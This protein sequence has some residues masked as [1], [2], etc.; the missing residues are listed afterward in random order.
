MKKQ[1]QVPVKVERIVE[2]VTEMRD[3]IIEEDGGLMALLKKKANVLLMCGNYFYYGKLSGVNDTCVELRNPHIVY[4]TG[5][6]SSKDFKDMQKLPSETWLVH[7]SAIE[8]FGEV[9]KK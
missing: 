3:E 7:I 1:V 5:D 9:D 4:E 6:W 2:Q 8:S